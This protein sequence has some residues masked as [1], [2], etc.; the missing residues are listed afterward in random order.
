M[1][2]EYQAL[3]AI[4]DQ[5]AVGIAQISLDGSLLRANDRYCQML[6]YSESELRTK[7]ISDITHPDDCEQTLAG[8]QRLL[9]GV[10]SSHSMSASGGW[11]LP[12]KPCN[13]LWATAGWSAYIR[14]M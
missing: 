12:A 7:R 11:T 10:I 3:Q 5:A 9:E 1:E 2:A 8:F 14:M 13:R 4:F 6:G